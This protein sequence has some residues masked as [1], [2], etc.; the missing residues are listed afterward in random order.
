MSTVA[1]G[2]GKGGT[3]K[4]DKRKGGSVILYVTDRA[5]GVHKNLKIVLTSYILVLMWMVPSRNF[6]F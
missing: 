5:G 4:A 1:G 2:R 3:Q 6:Y